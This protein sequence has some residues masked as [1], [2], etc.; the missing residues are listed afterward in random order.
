M[1][2]GAA[3]AGQEADA[4]LTHDKFLGGALQVWQPAN[5]YRAGVD[6]VLL[7]A[8]VPASATTV[9]ELGAGVGVASLCLAR[10]VAHA[11]ISALELQPDYAAL[12]QRNA[13]ENGL[14]ITVYQGDLVHMPAPLRQA[15]FDHVIANPPYFLRDRSLP[16]QDKGRETGMGEV[17]A[18]AQWVVAAARRTRDRGH[19]TFICRVERLPELVA[20]FSQ[21]LGSVEVLPITPRVGRESQL[22]LIRGRK[23]ARAAFRL[24]AGVVM[25]EGGQHMGDRKNYTPAIQAV[26]QAGAALPWAS[27]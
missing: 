13:R 12:A 7:A 15:R 23:G 11:Q 24:H 3:T 1:A 5:G 25:H 18:L 9:L 26:L 2:K 4:G 17:V 10:R 6:P 8:S 27:P 19:V 20:L 14:P 16:A 22:V 21:Y